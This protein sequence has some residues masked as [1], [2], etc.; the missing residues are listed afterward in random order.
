MDSPKRVPL[1]AQ[2]L[3]GIDTSMTFHRSAFDDWEDEEQLHAS[4]ASSHRRSLIRKSKQDRQ[5]PSL[6][7]RDSKWSTLSQRFRS[8]STTPVALRLRSSNASPKASFDDLPGRDVA[9]VKV[10]SPD[11]VSSMVQAPTPIR[12]SF[13]TDQ[14]KVH[15]ES[16][17]RVDRSEWAEARARSR[18]LNSSMD[19][20]VLRREAKTPP[21]SQL[22]RKN[23]SDS[24]GSDVPFQHLRAT[25][26]LRFNPSRRPRAPFPPTDQFDSSSADEGKGPDKVM[27]LSPVL[28]RCPSKMLVPSRMMRPTPATPAKETMPQRPRRPT[29]SNIFSDK[30]PTKPISP[31]RRIATPP[32]HPPPSIPVP[33]LPTNTKFDDSKAKQSGKSDGLM[34]ALGVQASSP[35]FQIEEKEILQTSPETSP[36]AVVFCGEKVAQTFAASIKQIEREAPSSEDQVMLIVGGVQFEAPLS[37]LLKRDS[38]TDSSGLAACIQKHL[39]KQDR[40]RM[41]HKSSNATLS[42]PLLS[43]SRRSKNA[44]NSYDDGSS[45]SIVSSSSSSDEDSEEDLKPVFQYDTVPSP[46]TPWTEELDAIKVEDNLSP[47]DTLHLVSPLRGLAHARTPTSVSLDCDE[48]IERGAE[49]DEN[50]STD[51]ISHRRQ[52]AT[53]ELIGPHTFIFTTSSPTLSTHELGAMAPIAKSR[54]KE[55]LQITLHRDPQPY[56]FILHYLK[57]GSLSS[58]FSEERF[59]L[60]DRQRALQK[61]CLESRWLG[62]SDLAEKCNEALDAMS[63]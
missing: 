31:G 12:P 1:K 43:H 23:S 61:V 36:Q 19:V 63:N 40:E 44:V 35:M 33:P 11:R 29:E 13:L 37:T 18:A 49:D 15:S 3:M 6:P 22:T 38:T 17:L 27:P 41:L 10:T 25:P 47:L 20:H 54:I 4:I 48:S 8:N 24:A 28:A 52:S 50:S 16:R 7:P 57:T 56:A 62:Y 32:R 42:I 45:P 14:R 2:R 59:P 55:G 51:V 30:S 34:I 21:S 5:Q 46:Q 58:F 9:S 26:P 53:P 60:V 39:N